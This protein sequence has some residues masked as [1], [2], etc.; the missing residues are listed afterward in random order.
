M[1]AFHLIS[2]SYVPNAVK[3]YREKGVIQSGKLVEAQ[4]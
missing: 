4:E 2:V 3:N 1:V